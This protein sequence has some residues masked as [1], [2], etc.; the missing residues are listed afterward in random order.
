M[1]SR[2]VVERSAILML[3]FL[4]RR[5]LWFAITLWIVVTVLAGSG[6]LPKSSE[7]VGRV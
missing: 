6:L 2:M 4:A 3:R 5:L 1:P 7:T